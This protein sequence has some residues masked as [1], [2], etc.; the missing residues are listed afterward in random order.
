LEAIEKER[1]TVIHGVPT[2]FIAELGHPDFDRFD[3]SS[4]RTGVMAG[5][6]C[7]VEVMQQVID[8]MGARE[9]TVAYGQTEAAPLITLTNTDDTVERRVN[10]VGAAMPNVEI[11]IA[12][13]E[14]GED[15]PRGEQGELWSRST[16]NMRGYYKMPEAT[17]AAI[18]AE[19]WLHTGDLAIMDE[20]GYCKITG[21]INDM[22]IRGG[23]NVYPRE[24]EEFL[25]THPQVSDV[26]VVG[27]PDRRLGEEV[28]AWVMLKSG[29]SATEEDIKDFCRGHIAHYKIP[30]YIKFVSEFPM[31]ITGKIQKFRMREL[32][33]EELALE[34]A[35]Q[36]E[37][38]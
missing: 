31:T 14:T 16:M 24:I 10:T 26:Q 38:A 21:R 9:M 12:D 23:E 2:M 17:A 25:Y 32:A 8:R 27:V 37:T 5:S 22:I 3:L 34:E 7:P 19:G 15:L 28:M 6:P 11:R 35:S 4:L 1:C 20:E 30:R 33:I 29:E 13:P 18:D 36:V